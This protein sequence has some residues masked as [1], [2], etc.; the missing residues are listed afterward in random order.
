MIID[1][2]THLSLHPQ[3]EAKL[4]NLLESMAKNRIDKAIALAAYFPRKNGSITNSEIISL[5]ENN[6]NI[7]IFGS[8]DAENN[9]SSGLSELEKLLKEEKIAGIKLYPGY[10]FIFPNDPRLNRLYATAEKFD[11]PVMFHSGLV[12]RNTG[13]L[14]YTDPYFID[15]VATEFPDL[16]IIISHL[17]DPETGKAISVAHKNQNVYLDISGLISNT[18]KSRGKDKKWQRQSEN[19]IEKVV[20]DAITEL[21]GTEKIIFGTDWPISSHESYLALAR[22]LEE[23][24]DLDKYEKEL[25]M[26]KNIRTILNI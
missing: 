11:I 15:E 16:K 5:A 2:H 24:L 10:Q 7:I 26:S 14:K 20:A 6:K 1:A 13:K 17:G 21:M 19:L 25:M 23:T 4:S 8:L 9:F 12:Y 22:S 18:T 3:S